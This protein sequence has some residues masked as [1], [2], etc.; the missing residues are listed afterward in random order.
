MT[1]SQDAYL[2]VHVLGAL[3]R[4]GEL[5]YLSALEEIARRAEHVC[6]RAEAIRVLGELG[7]ARYLGLLS[8]AVL[9]DH[10]TCGPCPSDLPAAEEAAIA[11]S[12]LG[13][14]EA[15]TAL[16]GGCLTVPDQDLPSWIGDWLGRADDRQE[17]R[18]MERRG[19]CWGL[20]RVHPVDRR[21]YRRWH[22]GEEEQ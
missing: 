21:L 1:R 18:L 7:A 19:R 4:R 12:Q 20:C 22:D 16:V 2:R 8:R 13:T 15:L 3:A 11:L 17:E 10:A 6:V 5:P 9:E 14:P